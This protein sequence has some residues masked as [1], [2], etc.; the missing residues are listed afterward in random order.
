MP[1]IPIKGNLAVETTIALRRLAEAKPGET[2]TY[3]ELN[4]L[5]GCDVR[6]RRNVLTTSTNKL[7]SEQGMVFVV[8]WGRGVRL[9]PN[10]E[11]PSLST[12]DLRKLSKAAKRASRRLQAVDYD[13]LSAQSK[14]Q[15]NTS[16][17]ILQFIQKGATERTQKVIADAVGN[18]TRPLPM[19]ETLKLF[20]SKAIQE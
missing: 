8:D 14:L 5:C 10:E 19:D 15:H 1:Y 18:R 16:L 3:T 7:L 12:A 13:S 2:V 6:H 17:T 11:V 9:V 4:A 20:G